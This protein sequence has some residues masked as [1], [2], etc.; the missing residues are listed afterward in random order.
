MRAPAE[1]AA[2]RA[3]AGVLLLVV[4]PLTA[5]L[6][7]CAGSSNPSPSLT[8]PVSSAPVSNGSTP[9]GYAAAVVEITRADGTTESYCV[10]LATT[11]AQREQGLMHVTSLGRAD[12]MLFRFG[13]EQTAAFWMKDTVLPLSVGYFKGDGRFVSAADMEP[14]P[15]SEPACP[16]YP[17]TAPYADALE[18]VQGDLARLGVADRSR[19]RVTGDACDPAG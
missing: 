16:T 5:A 1:R 3:A 19:L 12:G 4:L 14:C 15:P 7:A 9:T 17:A 18:V 10:W 13:T 11:P 2:H 6:A 8:S